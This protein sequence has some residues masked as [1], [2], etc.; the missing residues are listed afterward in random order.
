MGHNR[1]MHALRIFAIAFLFVLGL[2]RISLHWLGF[3][4]PSTQAGL[5]A[6][7]ASPLIH[8]FIGFD[9]SAESKR[10]FSYKIFYNNGAIENGQHFERI[11]AIPGLHNRRVKYLNETHQ[12]SRPVD[13]LPKTISNL[14]CSKNVE[15]FYLFEKFWNCKKSIFN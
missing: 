15:K 1:E 10:F 2:A 9:E 12:L 13:S 11:Y 8:P 4:T 6:S 5:Q 3:E 7:A 14:Y